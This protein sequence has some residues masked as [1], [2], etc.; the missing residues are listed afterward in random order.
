M[1]AQPFRFSLFLKIALIAALTQPGFYSAAFS[2]PIQGANFAV[3]SRL[4]HRHAFGGPESF[5]APG[6]AVFGLLAI[7]VVILVS[8]VVWVGF[9][10]L[11]CRLRFTLFDLIVYKRGRVGQ[12]WSG[13]SRQAWRYFGLVILVSLA[14]LVVAAVLIGPA[15]LNVFRVVRPLAMAGPNANPF[16]IL[17]AMLPLLLV[18]FAV[19]AL[20]AVVD[21]LM[22]DFLLPPIAID[23]APLESAFARF[24]AL[25]KSDF[26]GV[27]VYVLLRFAVGIG[28]A[29]I[30]MLLVFL[31]LGV[32]GLAIFGVGM[33]LY[34]TLWASVVGQV[35]CVALALVV[36]ILVLIIYAVAM[37]SVYGIAA[38]FKQSYAV[39]FYGGR[40]TRLGDTLE[41]PLTLAAIEAPPTPLQGLSPFGDAPPVW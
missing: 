15:M 31:V 1:L 36:G 10:Y 40:Y 7:V 39:T 18:I 28:L 27:V 8:I 23:D 32:M 21:A 20:W 41:P 12:A 16:P 34:H 5:A 38:V 26:G 2:Y 37:I 33:V 35:V 11:Y 25:L 30:L 3:M 14:F 4:P 29:W 13:H 24:F 22:Q 6:F 9:T 17:A 19:A